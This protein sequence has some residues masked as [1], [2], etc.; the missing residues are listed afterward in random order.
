[1]TTTEALL[2]T[3]GRV[4]VLDATFTPVEVV[5]WERA[6]TLVLTG[7]AETIVESDRI[8]SSPSIS[9]FVPT[10]IRV[11]ARTVVVRRHRTVARKKAIHV[12]DR[13][14]CAYC[15]KVARSA[16]E[17]ASMTIDHIVPKSAGGSKTDPMNVITACRPCNGHKNDRTPEQARMRM[18]F[19]ARDLTWRERATL[20]FSRGGP[21]PPEWEPFVA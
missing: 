2:D 17:R 11:V 18:L 1:M 16:A 6:V 4:L 20:R 21:L 3:N 7:R 12:R 19:P 5:S 14:T 8:V 10:V 15:G 13:W 9:I